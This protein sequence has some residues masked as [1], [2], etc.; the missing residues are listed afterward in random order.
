MTRRRNLSRAPTTTT[1]S[2]RIT[3]R[4][5]RKAEMLWALAAASAA[6]SG[7]PR[8]HAQSISPRKQ[9]QEPFWKR[10]GYSKGRPYKATPELWQ[11]RKRLSALLMETFQAMARGLAR[12]MAKRASTTLGTTTPPTMSGPPLD[13]NHVKRDQQQQKLHHQSQAATKT[14]FYRMD[15]ND[16]DLTNIQKSSKSQPARQESGRNSCQP[17]S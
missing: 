1:R 3:T 4:E 10:Q 8:L 6:A 11:E 2:T 7:T 9:G 12:I 14:S 15:A 17:N 13:A 16:G 5:A